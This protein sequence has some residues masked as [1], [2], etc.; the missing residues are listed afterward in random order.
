MYDEKVTEVLPDQK[1]WTHIILPLGI[2]HQVKKVLKGIRI[3]FV[4]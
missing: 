4:K 2:E 3:S 1:L